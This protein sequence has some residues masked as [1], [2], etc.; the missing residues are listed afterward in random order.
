MLPTPCQGLRARLVNVMQRSDRLLGILL[1]LSDREALPAARLAERFEVSV[2]TIYRDMDALGELGIPFYAETGRNGGFR[3][4]A[5]YRLPPVMFTEGEAISLI[6]GITLLDRLPTR[7]HAADLAR[8]EGKLLN[9]LPPA[10]QQTLR[11]ARRIIGFENT[12]IDAFHVERSGDGA[13]ADMPP[14]A[15]QV[16]AVLDEFLGAIL[17]G[18]SVQLEYLSPYRSGG[19]RTYDAAAAGLFWDR[20]CWYLV[21]TLPDGAARTW[22]AD[23]VLEFSTGSPR[24]GDRSVT[25]I[26]AYLNRAWLAAAMRDWTAHHPVQIAITAEQAQRLQLDWYYQHARFEGRPDGRVLMAFGQDRPEVV[27]ELV[28]WLGPGAELLSPVKWRDLLR[29]DLET[30]LAAYV[31]PER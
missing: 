19:A 13:D 17:N 10:L 5:G 20:D 24:R 14:P 28:R 23:R 9:A 2:R 15:D 31:P 26:S 16:N 4:V 25:D 29:R 27:L 12:A 18:S 22:R 7:P 1:Q 21:G 6:L 11:E 3:L 30:M 8:A